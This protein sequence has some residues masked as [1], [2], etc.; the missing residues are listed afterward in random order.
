M[1]KPRLYLGLWGPP[2]AA[3]VVIFAFS[4]MPS[5]SSHHSLIVFILR[6]V[7]HFSEYA[8]LTALLW[9]AVR[10]RARARGDRALILAWA[11]A[12]AYAA[13]D[14]FHQTFVSGRVGTPRDVLIDAAGAAVA[15]LV[16]GRY[17]MGPRVRV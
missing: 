4:A 1:S 10:A 7:A 16:I 3:M 2:I 14:E 11:L 13:T 8:I 15:V 17:A 6:K 5:D 12:V 9:R